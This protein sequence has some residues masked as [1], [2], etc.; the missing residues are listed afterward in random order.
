MPFCAIENIFLVLLFESDQRT[1]FSN[2]KAFDPL[3]KKLLFLETTGVT[4][5]GKKIYFVLTVIVFILKY[6]RKN[7]KG[8]T[9]LN[10]RID[11]FNFGPT[12]PNKPALISDK[13]LTVNERLKMTVAKMLCS[14]W[15]FDWRPRSRQ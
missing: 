3:I 10:F 6:F 1:E 13:Y 4:V 12:E 7:I 14:F 2:H 9:T 11:M 8:F 5:N 15:D